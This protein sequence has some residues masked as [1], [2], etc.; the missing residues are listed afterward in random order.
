[1]KTHAVYVP[2]ARKYVLR[3][4]MCTNCMELVWTGVCVCMRCC[5]LF[6]SILY[7]LRLCQCDNELKYSKVRS[8]REIAARM[9]VVWMVYFSL[10]SGN[11]MEEKYIHFVVVA[12]VAVVGGVAA[13]VFV[14]RWI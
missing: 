12:F 8:V 13:A 7:H 11:K 2:A 1:M 5:V 14:R 4:Y 9:Y 3:V 10:S 6:G